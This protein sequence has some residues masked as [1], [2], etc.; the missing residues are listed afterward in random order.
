M[1]GAKLLFQR[2]MS[3]SLVRVRYGGSVERATHLF[4]RMTFAERLKLDT[5]GTQAVKHNEV[6]SDKIR[7]KER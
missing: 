5:S 7:K 6:S 3:V 1:N 4:V 2:G